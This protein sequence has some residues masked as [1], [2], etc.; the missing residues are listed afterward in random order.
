MFDIFNFYK[1]FNIPIAPPEHKHCRYGW[2]QTECPFCTGN[3][4]YHLGFYTIGGYFCC[5]R[6]GGKSFL[7]TIARLLNARYDD[8]ERLIEPYTTFEFKMQHRLFTP[9]KRVSLPEGT[10]ELKKAHIRYLKD[11][12]FNPDYLEQKYLILGTGRTGFYARR[13]VAPIY[14]KNRLVSFQARDCTGY[15]TS[16]Y[17]AAGMDNEIIHHKHTLYN[18]EN[19]NGSSI[20]VLEGITDVWRFGDHSCCVFGI[21]YKPA[22]VLLLAQYQRVIIL[23]DPDPQAQAQADKLAGELSNLGVNVEVFLLDGHDPAEIPN[24]EVRLI[25]KEFKLF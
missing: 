11:R 3:P 7:Y 14:M 13:I 22:Q 18:Q 21:K 2:V 8:V 17:L 19:C 12:K 1:D 16:K 25:K 23:F 15:H 9:I 5:W 10:R 4:G 20:L 24:N 6:C